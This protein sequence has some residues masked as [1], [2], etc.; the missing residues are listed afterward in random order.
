MALGWKTEFKKRLPAN[1]LS[2]WEVF[3]LARQTCEQ[4]EWEYL[5]VDEYS[6]T[7]TTPL[8][9]TISEE[10][11][12]IRVDGENIIFRSQGESLEL[13][14]GGRNKKNI[15]D[16]LIPAFVSLKDKTSAGALQTLAENLKKETLNQL[17]SGRVSGEKITFGLRDHEMTLFLILVNI[18]VFA[19]MV[20]RGVNAYN[21]SPSDITAWGGNVREYVIAGDWWRLVSNL[22][23]HIGI[24]LLIANMIGLYFIGIMVETI[25][26]KVKF[27]IAYITTGALASLISIYWVGLGVRAGS[28]GAIA[29]LY[30]I[31]IIFAS[32]GYVNKRFN[33]VWFIGVL[34]YIVFSVW[35]GIAGGVDNA[36]GIGGLAAGLVVGLLFY[37]FHFR[38][39]LARAGGTR[40]SI[41]IMLVTALLI[42]LYIKSVR[43]DSL[44]FEKAVMKLNQ[45]ELKAMTEMQHLQDAETSDDAAKTLKEEALPLWKNF[46]KELDKTD[47]YHL[48]VQFNNKRKLLHR[49]AELRIKQTQLI[50]QSM[51]EDTEKYNPEIEKISAEIETL[52]DQIGGDKE[53]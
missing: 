1:G 43:N 11:I 35:I 52:I 4:L 48:D 49:Y 25:L 31:L 20:L 30:G 37:L 42:F 33:K 40:I 28:S 44:R 29:G 14:E 47:K 26:G 53:G 5:V 6:F 51:A 10:I 24:Q 2:N 36:A 50:Y 13:Y 8:H 12:T 3:A 34:A 45:I 39:N 32:S 27:L 16:I 19:I 7:A 38:K 22:F 9:W 18:V 15:E 41:E 46:Q 21:P 17:K 23:V